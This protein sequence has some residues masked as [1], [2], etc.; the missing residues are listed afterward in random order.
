VQGRTADF[1]AQITVSPLSTRA[2]V[3]SVV[4][5]QE[6]VPI[7]GS[8]VGHLWQRPDAFC[9]R[10]MP[11]PLE[12]KGWALIFPSSPCG[13]NSGRAPVILAGRAAALH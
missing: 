5:I 10:N 7:L 6:S 1:N 4:S 9:H 11:L 13:R 3:V 8:N 2:V 12:P